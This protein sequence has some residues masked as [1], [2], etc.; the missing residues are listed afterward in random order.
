VSSTPVETA[1]ASP[2]DL[3]NREVTHFVFEKLRATSPRISPAVL[4]PR[5]G[6]LSVFCT[7]GLEAAQL[8]QIAA[9]HVSPSREPK[10]LKAAATWDAALVIAQE[11]SIERDDIPHR[12]ANIRAWPEEQEKLLA[13]TQELARAARLRTP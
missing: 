1:T 11:L 3:E 12:H 4:R 10:S 5:Y 2:S 13:V 8:F 9:A 7:G 6:E